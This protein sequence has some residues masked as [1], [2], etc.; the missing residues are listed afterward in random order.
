MVMNLSKREELI[1]LII[2]AQSLLATMGSL[3]YSEIIGYVP[4]DLCWI[5]RIF[6]Y[7]LVIIYGLALIKKDTKIALPGIILSGIGLCISIYHYSLQ[8]VPFM[9]NA[10]GFCGEIPCNL[11]YVNYFGFITI[12][13]LA[14]I[15]FIVIFISHLYVLYQQKS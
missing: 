8:K 13:F 2:W 10:G 6:M 9:Q 7:P 5:Q 15:A 14:G 11:Q 4:C 12:P 1:M 3:F